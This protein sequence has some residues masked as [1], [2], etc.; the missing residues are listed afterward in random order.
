MESTLATEGLK[1]PLWSW[2]KDKAVGA[3]SSRVKVMLETGKPLPR[4]D[5][6]SNFCPFGPTSK[7]LTS[8]GNVWLNP[9]IVIVIL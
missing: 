9:L 7:K 6:G 3:S 2:V 4:F 1:V 5:I 8:E